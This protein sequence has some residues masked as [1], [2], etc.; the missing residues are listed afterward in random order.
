MREF[1]KVGISGVRGIVGQSFTPQLATVFAKAFGTYAGRGN[2]LV[3]RDTRPS[4][5]MFELAVAAG[6]QSVG[7]RPLIA[8]I[9][10]TPTLLHL[11][12]NRRARGAIMI[13]ASH[14]AAPWN[15]LKFADRRGLFLSPDHAEELFDIYHQG[16]F[17]MVPEPE[18]PDALAL[19]DP[20]HDHFAQV[21]DYVD[22]D[23]IAARRFKVAAD[24]CNGVGALHTRR[25]LEQ[26]G[27]EVHTCMDMRTDLFE[28]EPEPCP[29]NLG[30]LAS[31]VAAQQC[32]VGFAQDPD[33][34]RLAL[35]DE[36]GCA[37]GEDL[38]VALTVQQVLSAHQKGPIAV[39]LS[40]SSILD[41]IARQHDVTIHK[42]RIGEIHVVE[43]MLQTGAVVGGEGN[44]GVIVPA[45]HACRDSYAG[46]AIVL[47]RMASSGLSVSA[48][49]AQ[50][51]ARHMVKEKLRIQA[52]SGPNLL[53]AIRKKHEGCAVTLLDG[54]YVDL[55]DGWIHA[56]L[57][58][59]E[60]VLRL[61]AESASAEG[62]AALVADVRAWAVKHMA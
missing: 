49:R 18:L 5:R 58:N 34:D 26:L 21:L 52:G 44:G 62:A 59:T 33:G 8:G 7:C 20:C 46:M 14:N 47:E 38:T 56:R 2:V 36:S 15:A 27:C 1:L 37:L 17:E 42:T 39:N 3:G 16:S 22:L 60:P 30:T 19:Q 40:T 45:I 28:R 25:F 57:S 50:L 53:R 12:R 11:A 48:L 9:V 29:E 6:L 13:T 41:D 24:C 10:P 23:A 4:G 61:Y 54:V 31:L 35:I 55:E 43:T 32:D 51:P